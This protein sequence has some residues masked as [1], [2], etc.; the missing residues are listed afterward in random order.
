MAR[1]F[2]GEEAVGKA[3]LMDSLLL[4]HPEL[5]SGVEYYEMT[6]EEKFKHWWE[7]LRTVMQSDEMHSLITDNSKQPNFNFQWSYFFPG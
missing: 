6:R 2:F 7:R 4:K 1:F 5:V 3:K